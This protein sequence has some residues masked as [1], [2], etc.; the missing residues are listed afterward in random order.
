MTSGMPPS[1]GVPSKKQSM[2][3]EF[4]SCGNILRCPIQRSS[5][6][7]AHQK[8]DFLELET[9]SGLISYRF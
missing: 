5:V 3:N 6:L 4:K 2:H 7:N 8:L 9:V 1:N